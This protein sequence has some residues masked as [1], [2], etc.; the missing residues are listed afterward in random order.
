MWPVIQAECSGKLQDC[1]MM[2]NA[3]TTR[4]STCATTCNAYYQCG[5]DRAPP[6][7]LQT[8]R[9]N[10]TPGYDGPPK[11]LNAASNNNTSS[12]NSS[13]SSNTKSS[14]SNSAFASN[15]K[16]VYLLVPFVSTVAATMMIRVI[17]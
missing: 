7:Y 10:D 1:Q 2:C 17:F 6:S 8:E 5:T 13:D 3:D 4:S 9:P 15:S 14:N 12:G 11:T 16:S